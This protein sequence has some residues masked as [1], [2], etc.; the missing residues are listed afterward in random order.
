[1]ENWAEGHWV[2]LAASHVPRPVPGRRPAHWRDGNQACL[3]CEL[4]WPCRAW[5]AL[6]RSTLLA[7]VTWQFQNSFIFAVACNF[8][9]W[10]RLDM[11]VP[12]RWNWF[13]TYLVGCYW[14]ISLERPGS[15]SSVGSLLLLVCLCLLFPLRT[16]LSLISM[17]FICV[18]L[19]YTDLYRF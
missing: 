11:W 8:H 10:D 6:A 7:V 9:M 16:V 1:M 3:E 4:G 13:F 2:R 19:P 15:W 12:R 14:N 18:C 5:W 17:L